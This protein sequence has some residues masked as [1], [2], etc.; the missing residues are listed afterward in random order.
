[1]TAVFLLLRLPVT[2]IGF[3]D[4]FVNIF[5]RIW[6]Y[7]NR[8]PPICKRTIPLQSIKKADIDILPCFTPTGKRKFILPQRDYD[9]RCFSRKNHFRTSHSKVFSSCKSCT[10]Q[11]SRL[12]QW[13]VPFIGN[14]KTHTPVRRHW[15]LP[16]HYRC[17][18]GTT[19]YHN[20]ARTLMRFTAPKAFH[21]KI[22][23][24]A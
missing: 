1:M 7:T 11:Q 8:M 22:S 5:R 23:I 14:T 10:K 2:M 13:R 21:S 12:L 3:I 17:P 9:I 24:C 6:R 18:N 19:T 16:F 15:R 20:C 4:M